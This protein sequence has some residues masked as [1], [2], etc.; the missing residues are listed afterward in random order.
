HLLKGNT[1]VAIATAE[2]TIE[3]AHEVGDKHY[4]NMAGI[5]LAEGLML[6]GDPEESEN[7]LR[8]IESNDPKSDYF[9]LGNIQRIRGLLALK[10]KE[11]ELAIHYFSRALTTFEAG[12]DPFHQAKMH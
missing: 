7:A 9:V 6:E 2:A 5:A 4:A 12:L 8:E 10:N 1:A 3:Q 11:R